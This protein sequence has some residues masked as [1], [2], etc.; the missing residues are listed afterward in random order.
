MDGQ[1]HTYSVLYYR[2]QLPT[3]HKTCVCPDISHPNKFTFSCILHFANCKS[4][5]EKVLQIFCDLSNLLDGIQK[6][7]HLV[8][9]LQK[10]SYTQNG[11]LLLYDV[12]AEEREW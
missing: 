3:Y 8:L 9:F 2:F 6:L 7:C 12:A 10:K 4:F 1:I 5:E 11:L